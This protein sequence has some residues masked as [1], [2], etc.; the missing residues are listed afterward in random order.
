MQL[1]KLRDGNRVSLWD[2]QQSFVVGLEECVKSSNLNE[3][4]GQSLRA[5]VKLNRRQYM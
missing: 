5:Q 2:I 3:S 1:Y 4:Y